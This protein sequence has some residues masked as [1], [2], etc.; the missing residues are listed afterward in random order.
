VIGAN[1]AICL[2]A[3]GAGALVAPL[4]FSKRVRRYAW[5]G[6]PVGALAAALARPLSLIDADA[7]HLPWV[8]ML[9]ALAAVLFAGRRGSID[10]TAGRI[11]I[12]SY[13]FLVLV[14]VTSV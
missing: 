2:V 10:R 7:L 12:A 4:P 3:V 9:V 6:L 5:A 1:V 14:V 8:L 11:L 13:P